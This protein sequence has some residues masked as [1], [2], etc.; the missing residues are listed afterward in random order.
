VDV[1]EDGWLDIYVACDSTPPHAAVGRD[2][3]LGGLQVAMDDAPFV[4]GFAFGPGETF[5]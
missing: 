1:D 5:A 4:R 3:H 2:L